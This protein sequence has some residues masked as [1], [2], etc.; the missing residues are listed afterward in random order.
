M[1][2]PS[3][4]WHRHEAARAAGF[5]LV[6]LLVVI[7]IIGTLVGLLLPAVQAAREAGRRTTCTNNIRE[8]ALGVLAYEAV[9]KYFPPSGY[10][11]DLIQAI[12][13]TMWANGG[14]GTAPD[15][16]DAKELGY[17]V[18]ILPYIERVNDYQAVISEM[19]NSSLSPYSETAGCVFLRRSP[20][21][22]CPS[23]PNSRGLG[24]PRPA[25]PASYSCNRGDARLTWNQGNAESKRG[26]FQREAFVSGSGT[27]AKLDRRVKTTVAKITDG[28]SKTLM[29]AEVAIYSTRNQVKG[30]IALDVW[31][32][33][34]ATPSLCLDRLDPAASTPTFTGSVE[35]DRL[36]RTWSRANDRWFST[37]L[38]P[39]GPSCAGA[40]WS[41]FGM[42]TP[43]SYHPGGVMVAMCDGST[44]FMIDSINAGDPLT[45]PPAASATTASPY[46]VWG[47]LG[48]PV[49]GEVVAVP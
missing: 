26:V 17:I 27:A 1:R 36:C 10:N 24:T 3:D 7:A 11:V 45:V 15:G 12:Q 28:M 47:A 18:A 4:P 23:D 48:T 39:N 37:V 34:T 49:G 5:T 2:A 13:P 25:G 22:V 16:R 40:S 32:V 42:Y 41:E 29:L 20:G 6:E 31:G 30:S 44:R 9:K 46:G 19:R 33:S 14:D 35:N 8:Y 43:S 38:P 21:G